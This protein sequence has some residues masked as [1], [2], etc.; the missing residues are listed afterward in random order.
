MLEG[1]G[2]GWMNAFLLACS[3][4]LRLQGDLLLSL[5]SCLCM[6]LLTCLASQKQLYVKRYTS[7]F[8]LS[9]N[10]FAELCGF[11]KMWD[12]YLCLICPGKSAQRIQE[13]AMYVTFK[14]FH[15]L[16]TPYYMLS[17]SVQ[18]GETQE[19]RKVNCS[20]ARRLK[21][22]IFLKAEKFP[23][24]SDKIDSRDSFNNLSTIW[25]CYN[26]RN[27]GYFCYT[28]QVVLFKGILRKKKHPAGYLQ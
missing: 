12:S 3:A 14:T 22:L 16:A 17:K 24:Y 6:I 10:I 27:F 20:L 23:L 19:M 21:V 13:N 26:R 1:T 7:C 11:T 25:C 28:V 15:L 8:S 4:A 2:T 5:Q 9:D 18:E